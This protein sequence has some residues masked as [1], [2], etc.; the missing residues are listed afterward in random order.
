MSKMKSF[1]LAK[2]ISFAMLLV[3]ILFVSISSIQ[4]GDVNE[5][6]LNSNE[7]IAL[8]IENND[9]LEIDGKSEINENVL[10]QNIKNQ[11]QLTSPTTKVY[12]NGKY[13]VTL[14]DSNTGK[15]LAN[16]EIKLSIDNVGYSA[17]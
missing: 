13:E 17:N 10:E 16:K 5:T 8:S 4:A 3:L 6:I 1:N 11:T 2:R 12:Y 14:I 7:D 15:S 9:Q